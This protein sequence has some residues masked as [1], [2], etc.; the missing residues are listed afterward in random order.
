M[1]EA[2]WD[3]DFEWESWTTI[4]IRLLLAILFMAVFFGFLLL[5]AVFAKEGDGRFEAKEFLD[6]LRGIT[7]WRDLVRRSNY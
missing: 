6:Q 1:T 3:A 7:N 5:A 2:E 4:G